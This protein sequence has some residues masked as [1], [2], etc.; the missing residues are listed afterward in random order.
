[1][2]FNTYIGYICGIIICILIRVKINI[3]SVRNNIT[4]HGALFF[5]ETVHVR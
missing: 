5:V 4:V 2:S 3:A 1:M